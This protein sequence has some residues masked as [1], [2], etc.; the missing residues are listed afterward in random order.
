MI[1][2]SLLPPPIRFREESRKQGGCRVFKGP[3]D[4][5]K[6]RVEDAARSCL[7]VGSAVALSLLHMNDQWLVFAPA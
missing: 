7:N 1:K 6:S 4:H 3:G 2:V 5:P